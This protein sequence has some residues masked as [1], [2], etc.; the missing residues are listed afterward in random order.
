MSEKL[1]GVRALWDGK[2]F[3]SR[4]GNEFY[5][6]AWFK[7]GLPDKKLDGEL[8]IGRGRF[9]DTLSV[10]KGGQGEAGWKK[11]RYLVFDA[12]DHHGPF[13]ERLKLVSRLVSKA[14]Y[15][16]PVNHA[17][18]RGPQHL[19]NE[20]R[21]VEAKGGEGLMLRKPGSYYEGVRSPTLLKVKTF[22][23]A[24]A[25]VIGYFP[26]KGRHEGVIGGIIVETPKG[27]R[28]KIGTGFTDEQRRKPPR[29]GA[30]ITYKYQELTPSGVPRF[31]SFLRVKGK[32]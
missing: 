19:H 24:E 28:F 30:T 25:K 11:V 3:W 15:A 32:E 5:A 20:L 18:C 13:E 22:H 14:P 4:G 1:D 29:I 16:K 26:G 17:Q 31:A 21:S 27:I 8:W 9:G 2:T 23:D 12:P 6:P 7:Q 10:V